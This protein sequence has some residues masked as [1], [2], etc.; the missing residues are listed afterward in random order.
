[1]ARFPGIAILAQ[2]CGTS[3]SNW[4]LG[5]GIATTFPFFMY[6]LIM[7]LAPVSPLSVRS[8]LNKALGNMAGTVSRASEPFRVSFPLFLA[9][10]SQHTIL[11]GLF[12]DAWIKFAKSCSAKHGKSAKEMSKWL[13]E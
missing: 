5:V 12:C 11:S 4:A 8:S 10:Y 1:M 2:S 9:F 3:I 7:G 6:F 13:G